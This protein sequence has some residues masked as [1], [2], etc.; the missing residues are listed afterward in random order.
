MGLANAW[1]L[2]VLAGEAVGSVFSPADKL[3]LPLVS[4][5]LFLGV[6]V[7]S[8]YGRGL[9]ITSRRQNTMGRWVSRVSKLRSITVAM[10][11]A[12]HVV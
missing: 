1:H 5:L 9:G 11:K 12:V 6:V 10:A 8:P 2:V 3:R 7:W 4:A